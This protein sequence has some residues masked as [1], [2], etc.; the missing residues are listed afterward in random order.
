VNKI[1]GTPLINGL[2]MG[3]LPLKKSIRRTKANNKKKA[4]ILD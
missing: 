3:K 1:I 2:E 4:A